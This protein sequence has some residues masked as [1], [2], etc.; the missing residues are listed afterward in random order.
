MSWHLPHSD[1]VSVCVCERVSVSVCVSMGLCTQS[2]SINI[3][4]DSIFV[5]LKQHSFLTTET[6]NM[7]SLKRYQLFAS[8]QLVEEKAKL[9]STLPL[10]VAMETPIAMTWTPGCPTIKSLTETLI[11]KSCREQEIIFLLLQ[12]FDCDFFE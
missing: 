12:T 8:Q 7:C 3:S 10:Y 4:N 5:P 11:S 2:H 1:F 9:I 6:V